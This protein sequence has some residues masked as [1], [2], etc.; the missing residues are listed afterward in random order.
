MMTGLGIIL[1]ITR[2]RQGGAFP[3]KLNGLRLHQATL[4]LGET[5]KAVPLPVTRLNRGAQA[6]PPPFSCRPPGPVAV[7]AERRT[8]SARMATIGAVQL[9][10]LIRTTCAL[11]RGVLVRRPRTIARTA[12]RFG[13]FP[14][15]SIRSDLYGTEECKNDAA[16]ADQMR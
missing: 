10:V 3:P 5:A 2:A 16:F 9:L 13:V 7:V 8:T 11:L 15:H 4:G 14:N 6:N 1:T 12:L